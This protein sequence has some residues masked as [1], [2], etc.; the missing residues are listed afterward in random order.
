MKTNL[1][2]FPIACFL[3]S[4]QSVANSKSGISDEPFVI[5]RVNEQQVKFD[6]LSGVEDGKLEAFHNREKLYA[7]IKEG[8]LADTFASTGF[9]GVFTVDNKFSAQDRHKNFAKGELTCSGMDV[10]KTFTAYLVEPVKE[11]REELYK[12]LSFSKA[13]YMDDFGSYFLEG[14]LSFPIL[15]EKTTLSYM[16]SANLMPLFDSSVPVVKNILFQLNEDV[17]QMDISYQFEQDKKITFSFDFVESYLSNFIESPF[18]FL[19]NEIWNVGE[20]EYSLKGFSLPNLQG[21]PV[22]SFEGEL[23]SKKGLTKPSKLTLLSKNKEKAVEVSFLNDSLFIDLKYP[24]TATHFIEGE[25]KNINSLNM[26]SKLNLFVSNLL[27]NPKNFITGNEKSELLSGLE[28]KNLAI[29]DKDGNKKVLA[30]LKFKDNISVNQLKQAAQN[31]KLMDLWVKGDI[32]LFQSNGREMKISF[33]E[34]DEVLVNEKAGMGINE[35]DF[36]GVLKYAQSQMQESVDFYITNM[37]DVFDSVYILGP[38]IKK[39]KTA[40]QVENIIH[41]A[42]KIASQNYVYC[43]NELENEKIDFMYECKGIEVALLKGVDIPSDVEISLPNEDLYPLI[44]NDKKTGR[45]LV[46]LTIKFKEKGLCED[47]SFEKKTSCKN[48]ELTVGFQPSIK[49]N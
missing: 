38:I 33:N 7:Y 16:P 10:F 45:D 22:L 46:Y 18:N 1:F 34:T 49:E 24:Q 26:L 35:A 42:Q 47:V 4:F 28:I 37:T 17:H 43:L 41:A 5:Y 21:E 6:D 29:Y 48:N 2:L 19:K 3:F 11:K 23:N 9:E 12:C 13:S 31:P 8:R 25:F 39:I 15:T 27:K 20:N 40:W 30:N 36:Y 32:I 14:G 44:I